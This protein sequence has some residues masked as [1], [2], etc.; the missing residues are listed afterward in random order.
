M[1]MMRAVGGTLYFLGSLVMVYNLFMTMRGGSFV[2]NEEA[3]ATVAESKK[4]KGHEPWGWHSIIEKRPVQFFL[5]SFIAIAVGS[6]IELIP[7]FMVKTNVPTLSSVLPY[8]PLELEGRDVYIR[9]GCNNC[10]T[11][12]VRP[13]RSETERYGEYSKA[14]EF[15]YDHP[16]LWGSRRTDPTCT[17][18]VANMPMAGTTITCMIRPRPVPDR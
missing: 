12:W 6:V 18:S 9:E 17:V 5:W 14:G 2:A 4:Q 13:F 7:M 8:T 10:H 15:V 3:Q 1:Y 11:Q 16:F